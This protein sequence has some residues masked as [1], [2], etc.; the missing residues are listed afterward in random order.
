MVANE[1]K[2]GRGI[3]VLAVVTGVLVVLLTLGLVVQAQRWGGK[4]TRAEVALQQAKT[5]HEAALAAR[6]AELA[7]L[8]KRL[9]QDE[10]SYAQLLNDH[11][12]LRNQVA[13]GTAPGG[14][15]VSDG[16]DVR[17][18]PAAWMERLRQDDPERFQQFVQARQQH[19]Q[20]AE[21]A[22]KE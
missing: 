3:S 17:S 5:D 6:T 8:R 13:A 2:S 1:T 16:R 10:D 11:E 14:R 20:A 22:A 7:K 12:Q 19:Q 9:K 21:A 18:S 15:S 4:L